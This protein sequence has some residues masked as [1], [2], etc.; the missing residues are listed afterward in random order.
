MSTKLVSITFVGILTA[1][2]LALLYE[3]FRGDL[4]AV[5]MAT[6]LLFEGLSIAFLSLFLTEIRSDR[7]IG[8]ES[9]WGGLG[10]GLGGWRIS[11]SLIY[12]VCVLLFASAFVVL[13]VRSNEI[14]GKSIFTL[15][16]TSPRTEEQSPHANQAAP[17]ETSGSVSQDEA[18]KQT[19]TV[20]P[21]GSAR[22]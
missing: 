7:N 2:A 6:I 5:F 20:T 4:D 10:G 3:V 16:H 18:A 8:I 15:A 13:V 1:S 9:R 21:G 14:F 19:E 22:K 11:P 17:G 12:L